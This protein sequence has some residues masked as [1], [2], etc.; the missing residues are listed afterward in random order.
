[1]L[2]AGAD[3]T[4][5][6]KLSEL[7]QLNEIWSFTL[8]K[9]AAVFDASAANTDVGLNALRELSNSARKTFSTTN[10]W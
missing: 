3:E 9:F 2:A 6:Y 5:D 7:R 1:V 8:G 4:F 10:D